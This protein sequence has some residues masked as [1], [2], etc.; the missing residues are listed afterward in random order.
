MLLGRDQRCS[1][2]CNTQDS[3]HDREH[4]V[5]NVKGSK[6]LLLRNSASLRFIVPTPTMGTLELSCFL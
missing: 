2:S 4:L 5:Q 3:P 1:T 6:L